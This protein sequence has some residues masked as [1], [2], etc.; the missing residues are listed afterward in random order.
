MAVSMWKCRT[1]L[2]GAIALIA[3]QAAGC[4]QTGEC[5][6]GKTCIRYMAWGNPQQFQAEQLVVNRFNQENP[7]LFVQLFSVPGSAYLQKA[8]LMLASRTAPDVLRIDHYAFPALQPKGYFH[9]LTDFAA[10][11]P[12]F[13]ESDYFP[14]AIAECKVGDRLF[15]LSTL[16]GGIIL[17]YN[18]TLFRAAGLADPYDLFKRGE[19]TWERYR[20]DAIRLT[21]FDK[22]G[23]AKVF[24]T[25]IPESPA[26]YDVVWSF[27]GDFLSPDMRH[28]VADSS[29]TVRAFQFLSDIVWKDHA[30]PTPAQFANSAYTFESGKIAMNF[31][32]MGMAPRYRDAAKGFDWD[33]CPPP[34]GD[35]PLVDVVKGNQ[36]VMA[37]NCRQPQAAW[38][39]MRFYTGYESEIEL[40][41]KIRRCFPTRI[42]VAKSPEFLDGTRPP[43]HPQ[44]FT[45]AV[46]HGRILPINP[47][48]QEWTTIFN[49][50]LD[51]LLSG[52][53]RD[54]RVV[55]E[56]A[57][58]KVNEALAEDPG[59]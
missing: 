53:E 41:G 2:L 1:S 17:Y 58:A 31:D 32:F 45:D 34:R 19:W 36:L 37:A 39:F 20:Q 3:I 54:A 5:P 9:D 52:R 42:A 18:K 44:A 50:E 24:G 15:G 4:R 8:T 35:G 10:A 22:D 12:T 16:Y 57:T 13:K 33:I 38:R 6:A 55:L 25:R 56:R 29:A 48:W 28:C 40:Y 43:A 7:D 11:D 26:Y 23:H 27:G 21:Q 59:F 30:A 51:N 47:R 14:T 49:S 46:E